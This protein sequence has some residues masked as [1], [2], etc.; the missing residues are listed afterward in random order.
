MLT[1]EQEIT[2]ILTGEV[3]INF[4]GNTL[5]ITKEEIEK[6]EEERNKIKINSEDDNILI[7]P[8]KEEEVEINSVEENDENQEDEE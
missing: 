7:L 4:T 6:L 8:E 5:P 2:D 3:N 1:G